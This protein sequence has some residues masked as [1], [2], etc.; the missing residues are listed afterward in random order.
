MY[1]IIA[2]SESD[3]KISKNENFESRVYTEEKT[4]EKGVLLEF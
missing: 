4:K 1:G 3:R 2:R